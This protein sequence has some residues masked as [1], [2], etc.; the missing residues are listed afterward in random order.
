VKVLYRQ[1][2]VKRRGIC[3]DR[4]FRAPLLLRFERDQKVALW[5]GTG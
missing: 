5:D 3:D 4:L 2:N 1:P